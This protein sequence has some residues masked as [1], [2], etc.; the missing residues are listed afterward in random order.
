MSFIVAT[1]GLQH[2]GGLWRKK[3]KKKENL[4]VS[5]SSLGFSKLNSDKM[6]EGK[7]K[8]CCY[9]ILSFLYIFCFPK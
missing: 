3:K 9:Y 5:A 2:R 7:K 6:R 8:Y 4:F 1:D